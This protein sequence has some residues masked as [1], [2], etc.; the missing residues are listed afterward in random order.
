VRSLL[1]AGCGSGGD[2]GEGQ[3]PAV[4]SWVQSP[5]YPTVSTVGYISC[6]PS[7]S[8]GEQTHVTPLPWWLPVRLVYAMNQ[9]RQAWTKGREGLVSRVIPT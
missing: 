5:V 4:R 7:L 6:V 2:R 9:G 3:L 8:H 1:T